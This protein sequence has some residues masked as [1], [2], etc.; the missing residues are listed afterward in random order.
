MQYDYFY[1]QID[2]I[3][4][5]GLANYI[6]T[7]EQDELELAKEH[8]NILNHANG[9]LNADTKFVLDKYGVIEDSDDDE[10]VEHNITNVLST[11]EHL[12]T[13]HKGE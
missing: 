4:K 2:Y 1:Y 6:Y 9:C 5:E 3:D 8:L 7:F 11:N 10:L 12:E 13:V